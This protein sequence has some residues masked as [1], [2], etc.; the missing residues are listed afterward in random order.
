M[1][2]MTIQQM[3]DKFNGEVPKRFANG[4]GKLDP[5]EE[6]I[7]KELPSRL[8]RFEEGEPAMVGVISDLRKDRDDEVLLPEGMDE[9]QYSGVVL[10]GHDHWREDIP[11]ARSLW[12]QLDSKQNP[13]QILAKTLYL[14]ELSELGNN[15]FLYRQDENPLGQSVGFRSVESVRIGDSGY[16]DIFKAW[17]PRAKAMLKELGIKPTKDE[18]EEPFRFFTKWELWEYSDVFIGSNPDALQ[19]AV[20]KSILTPDEAKGL[21]EFKAMAEQKDDEDVIAELRKRD[22]L[23]DQLSERIEVLAATIAGMKSPVPISDQVDSLQAIWNE[24]NVTQT[25]PDLSTLWDNVQS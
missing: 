6:I 13:A 15:V 10:W 21:V 20:S 4:L 18:F 7:T 19:V 9:S 3:T 16:D 23:I 1:S 2:V 24:A 22:D 17:V 14:R 5:T 8:L 25:D 12:R 11:H